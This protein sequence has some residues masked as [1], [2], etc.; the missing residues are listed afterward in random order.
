[1]N[2]SFRWIPRLIIC[3]SVA[4]CASVGLAPASATQTDRAPV[5][6]A[7]GQGVSPEDEVLVRAGIRL[8]QDEDAAI[9]GH[10][11]RRPVAVTISSPAADAYGNNS[12]RDAT[13]SLNTWTMRDAAPADRV[14]LVVHEYFHVW[15]ADA[16]GF[17]PD[18]GALGPAWLVEG[19]ANFVAFRALADVG[20]V[21][22]ED[23]RE[24]LVQLANG[25][26][27]EEKPAV[28]S[29]RELTDDASLV[30]PGVGCC[31]YAVATLAVER[32][33]KASG[34]AALGRYF[35]AIGKGEDWRA[36][37]AEVFGQNPDTFSATFERERPALL[38]PTGRDETGLLHTPRFNDHPSAV[39]V[40]ATAITVTRD[41]QTVLRATTADGAHCTLTVAAADGHAVLTE[42]AYADAAGGVFW[43]WT[44][45]NVLSNGAWA[46]VSCGGAPVTI[47]VTVGCGAGTPCYR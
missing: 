34:P 37:F 20:L 11:V 12:V 28:P 44:V 32:L 3:A 36:A 22:W 47:A 35:A 40:A 17:A 38:A 19:S 14:R 9:F 31:S 18:S 39:A 6:F 1:M 2:R 30:G 45:P 24:Y 41:Q 16:G 42:P 8:A 46:T 7:F 21:R 33:T 29:L 5:T 25:A 26:H 4:A 23:A 13:I 10:D 43:L 27:A 15:Q